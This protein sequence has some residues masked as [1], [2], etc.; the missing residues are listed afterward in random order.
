MSVNAFTGSTKQPT[1]A[2]LT[3]ALGPSRPVWDRLLADLAEQHGV[4]GHEWKS[5][6]PKAGWSFRVTRKGRTIVWLAPEH[7]AFMVAFVM[8]D[9]AMRIVRESGW[10]QRIRAAIE[11]APKYAEGTAIRLQ[12]KSPR[13]IAALM[14]LA[15]IKL[16]N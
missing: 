9:R 2:E 12:V 5:Y 1:D 3:A 11:N 15:A 10:P 16:A 6:S 7:H 14:K 4:T 8:G 13:D